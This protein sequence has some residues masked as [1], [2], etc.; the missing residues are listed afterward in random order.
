[1]SSSDEG[2]ENLRFRM[3]IS[4]RAP[5]WTATLCGPGLPEHGAQAEVSTMTEAHEAMDHVFPPLKGASTSTDIEYDFGPETNAALA[6]FRDALIALHNVMPE[7]ASAGRQASRALAAQ[8][9]SLRDAAEVVHV[10]SWSVGAVGNLLVLI[11]LMVAVRALNTA[12]GA[13]AL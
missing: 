12:S 5:G 11:A 2:I 13:R 1:M 6:T 8:G 3:V 10:P 7:Y 9:V 4:R